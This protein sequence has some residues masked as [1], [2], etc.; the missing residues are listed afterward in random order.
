MSKKNI[1]VSNTPLQDAKQRWYTTLKEHGFAHSAKSR[2]AA[3]DDSLGLLTA[4]PVYA[5]DSSPSYNAA[6]MDGIA[7]RFLPILPLPVKHIR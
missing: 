7:V 1:Y 4:E 2:E 6:A 5:R 3:V